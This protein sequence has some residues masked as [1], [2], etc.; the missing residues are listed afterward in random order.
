[1]FGAIA[2][3]MIFVLACILKSPGLA[4]LGG[5]MMV[6]GMGSSRDY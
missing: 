6:V 3:W 5:V 1:M 2:G 4:L